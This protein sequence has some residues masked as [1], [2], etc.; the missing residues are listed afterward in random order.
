MFLDHLT[1]TIH[2]VNCRVV[3]NKDRVGKWPSVH[4]W[5]EPLNELPENVTCNGVL[6]DL[7]MEDS[8]KR[9]GRKNG[10]LGATIGELV[11]ASTLATY[12]PRVRPPQSESIE[13]TLVGKDELL[14]AKMG[15]NEGLVLHAILLVSLKSRTHGLLFSGET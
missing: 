5:E 13:L 1:N 10:I 9:E 4:A 14:W 3:D 7:K 8:V 2:L 15:R 12:Q 6:D 11:A